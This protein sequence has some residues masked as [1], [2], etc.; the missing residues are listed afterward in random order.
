MTFLRALPVALAFAISTA[1]PASATDF[2]KPANRSKATTPAPDYLYSTIPVSLNAE[3]LA[4]MAPGDS[5]D[6]AL[7]NG[8][9]YRAILIRT[10]THANGDLSWIGRLEGQGADMA[11][12]ATMGANGSYAEI[13]TP[14]GTFGVVPGGA[15]DWLFDSA[16]SQLHQA[17]PAGQ[18]DARI[19][20]I[21]TGPVPKADPVC[22]D[23]TSKPGPQTTID[24]L[25]V[26]APDF[27]SAH[28]ATNV[29]TRLNS[30]L[31]NINNY[32]NNSNIAMTL[33]RVAT[34]NV[35]YGDANTID[36]ST[37]LDAI[38]NGTA[39]FA[40]IAALRNYYGADMVCSCAARRAVAAS[41]AW[42]GWAATT[43]LPSP[44]AST[45]CIR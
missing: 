36:D 31:T 7:P 25:A 12:I 34:I 44:G 9:T 15:H 43:L 20:P 29:E 17:R 21:S 33:R 35:S 10:E 32:Y 40:N 1:L 38:T 24:V 27:V 13:Q 28:G 42:P 2:F 26:L 22:A 8:K 23:I 16:L 18:T 37:A 39:P 3:A 41:P 14:D 6:L 11:V 19:P 30:L 45:S 4:A 5:A